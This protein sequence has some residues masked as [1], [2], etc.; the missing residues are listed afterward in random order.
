VK[1]STDGSV[2]FWGIS[3]VKRETLTKSDKKRREVIVSVCKS[4]VEE[5][6]EIQEVPMFPRFA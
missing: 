3:I 6:A 4:G 5:M 2:P 1:P